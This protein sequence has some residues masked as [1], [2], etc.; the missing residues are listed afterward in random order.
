MHK[1]LLSIV[2]FCLHC[3]YIPLS[4]SAQNASKQDIANGLRA[5]KDGIFANDFIPEKLNSSKESP[6][7]L[8]GTGDAL[9]VGAGLTLIATDLIVQKVIE[10]KK[11]V[12]TEQVFN[13]QSVNALDR[14]LMAPYRA[15][16]HHFGTVLQLATMLTPAL[17]LKTDSS[18]WFTIGAMYAESVMLAY[19]AKEFAKAFVYRARPYT[20][21]NGLPAN[22]IASGDWNNSFFSGHTTMA[23]NAATFTS[24]VYSKYFP[25]AKS[26]IPVI[27][28]SYGLALTTAVL[29]VASG[30]HFLTD[31][32]TGAL[33]GSATGF[34]VPF[35]HQYFARLR[36]EGL[37]ATISPTSFA[38]TY[39]Y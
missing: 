16:L 3:I 33:V 10:P 4:L 29:R 20:Y 9:I 38:L 5:Q 25:D 7:A 27:A 8:N 21:F 37:S 1:K 22:K 35:V 23:F 13:R 31:V 32:I 6:F 34:L 39:S 30:N 26:K 36:I 11:Q 15:S 12:F 28:G 19:G 18:E 2:F 24:Y 17:L 14:K